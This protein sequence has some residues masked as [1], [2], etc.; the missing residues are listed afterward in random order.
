M[1]RRQ[2]GF[3]ILEVLVAFAIMALVFGVLLPGQGD[4][5][6]RAQ[7]SNNHLLA[8][9]IL[10]SLVSLERVPDIDASNHSFALPPDWE[11]KREISPSTFHSVT[12]ITV[13]L[14]VYGPYG[15]FLAQRE[16]WRPAS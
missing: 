3:S 11:L 7:R 10:R 14:T 4:L 13:T 2:S 16:I 8:T 5:L 6:G 12:G 1:T 9:D 15:R